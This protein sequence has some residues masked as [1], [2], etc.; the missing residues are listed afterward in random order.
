MALCRVCFFAGSHGNWGGASRVLFSLLQLLDRSRFEPVVLLSMDGPATRDLEE[1]GVDFEIWGPVTELRSFSAYSKAVLRM[2]LWLKQNRIAIVHMNRANDWRPAEHVAAKLSG[3]PIVTHFHT[4]NVDR[5]PATRLTTAIAAVSDYVATHCEDM[6]VP[7]HVIHNTV[8]LDTFGGGRDIRESLGI[9]QDN[10]V[11]TFAGQIRRIKGVDL[12][13]SAAKRT[14][15]AD[16]RF[17]IVGRC[18]KGDPTD[19]AFTEQQLLDSISDDDRIRYLGY[20]TDM[21]DIYASSDIVVFP[22]RWEEPF[23]LILI[24]AGAAKKT[25]VATRVGG[26]PE[27]VVDQQTGLLVSPGDVDDLVAKLKLLIDNPELRKQMGL[28]A[29]QRIVDE[30]T[31]QPVRK[32]E[33]LYDSLV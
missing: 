18:R 19:D 1:M 6:G 9:G 3:V 22:S 23:G 10:L 14:V 27:V 17:L 31:T 30:F 21:P 33:A 5:A 15:G 32:L 2:I 29:Y 7:V 20:R 26:I 4:V 25:T 11:V 13:I 8:D 12:F 28:K 16:L 24:E